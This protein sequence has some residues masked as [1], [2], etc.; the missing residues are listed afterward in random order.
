VPGAVLVGV[1]PRRRGVEPV[2]RLPEVLLLDEATAQVD[3]LTE[4]A[5]RDCI[6]RAASTGAVVTVPG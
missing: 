5:I 2:V 3:G 6:H 4:A 1:E